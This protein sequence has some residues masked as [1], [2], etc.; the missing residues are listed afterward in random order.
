M[1]SIFP[2]PRILRPQNLSIYS[3]FTL[4][5]SLKNYPK[6]LKAIG[7]K[8]K[9]H[10]SQDSQILPK[11]LLKRL[12]S[13]V[14]SPQALNIGRH[15][16][17]FDFKA[18]E[19]LTFIKS[20]NTIQ[21]LTLGDIQNCFF[22]NS[23]LKWLTESK[24]LTRLTFVNTPRQSRSDESSLLNSTQ[25]KYEKTLKQTKL[26]SYVLG[27]HDT[28]KSICSQSD[29]ISPSSLRNFSI[30]PPH[31]LYAFRINLSHLHNLSILHLD[32]SVPF[33]DLLDILHSL[34][35]LDQLTHLTV[36]IARV[37]DYDPKYASKITESLKYFRSL[38]SLRLGTESFL[39]VSALFESFTNPSKLNQLVLHILLTDD[40]QLKQLAAFIE[41]L[42]NL[43]L[44]CIKN[45]KSVQGEASEGH[46][47]LFSAI[48]GLALLKSLWISLF[49]R[50]IM[51]PPN[52]KIWN[53][54]L[55]EFATCLKRL[56][57]LSEL[58]FAQSEV[59]HRDEL[60][61]LVSA[62][63]EKGSNLKKLNII[64]L[65][66]DREVDHLE[67]LNKIFGTLKNLEDLCFE[68]LQTSK[69]SLV[70]FFDLISELKWLRSVK[71]GGKEA[72]L[73]K[74][75][76]VRVVKKILMKYGLEELEYFGDYSI[77]EAKGNKGVGCIDIKKILWR[78]PR[79]E[80]VTVAFCGKSQKRLVFKNV[81]GFLP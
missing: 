7:I 79:L 52:Y 67:K 55:G 78:N 3:Q 10:Q 47:L 44:L 21:S 20:F 80:S 26:L 51:S 13:R 76:L 25:T 68:G 11:S 33:N 77:K 16:Q 50:N 46:R 1:P 29:L 70:Q 43:S 24:K 49:N 69:E 73:K 8:S 58:S 45:I 71:L 81:K 32:F 72:D 61:L 6:H 40:K 63:K 5:K 4:H 54:C 60:Q 48:P 56:P 14:K 57:K 30:I 74:A 65:E 31:F 35:T 22:H 34:P 66:R 18:N 28:I 12:Q 36:Y 42:P 41:K 17:F 15:Q 62:L 27:S 2:K 64:L 9:S 39:F 19:A 59:C 53:G 38:H 37:P 75:D 23:D